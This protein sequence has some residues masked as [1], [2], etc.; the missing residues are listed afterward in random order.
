MQLLTTRTQ[1]SSGCASTMRDILGWSAAVQPGTHR[2]GLE[3]PCCVVPH[4]VQLD[5][6]SLQGHAKDE[7]LHAWQK[8]LRRQL[9][10]TMQVQ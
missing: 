10:N 8:Q 5:G 2:D 9:A 4:V 6:A 7:G 1:P 3:G